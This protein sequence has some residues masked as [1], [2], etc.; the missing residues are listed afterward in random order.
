M[1]A[2]FTILQRYIN[3]IGP[4]WTEYFVSLEE[5]CQE[6]FLRIAHTTEDQIGEFMAMSREGK[7]KYYKAWCAEEDERARDDLPLKMDEGLKV[8]HRARCPN[9]QWDHSLQLLEPESVKAVQF[10]QFLDFEAD[11][12]NRLSDRKTRKINPNPSKLRTLRKNKKDVDYF[13]QDLVE[14]PTSELDILS[15]NDCPIGSQPEAFKS[16][17]RSNIRNLYLIAVLEN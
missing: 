11:R 16:R 2:A 1:K 4:L 3:K 12:S 10:A 7:L 14:Y 17:Q 9:V 13:S 15:L 8:L 5:Q 6:D